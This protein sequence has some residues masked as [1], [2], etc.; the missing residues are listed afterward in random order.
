MKCF[1][2]RKAPECLKSSSPLFVCLPASGVVCFGQEAFQV[3]V[4][5]DRSKYSVVGHDVQQTIGESNVHIKLVGEKVVAGKEDQN[6][7][8][9]SCVSSLSCK[10]VSFLLYNTHLF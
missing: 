9:S 2:F 5:D 8:I 1:G 3:F 4:G 6:N 7:F 10:D